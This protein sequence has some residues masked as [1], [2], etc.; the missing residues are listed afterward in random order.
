[1][2]ERQQHWEVPT[3]VMKEYAVEEVADGVQ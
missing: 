3:N 1:M 2:N